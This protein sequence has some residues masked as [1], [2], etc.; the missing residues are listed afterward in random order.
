[1]NS[2]CEFL[3]WDS[4]FFGFR[5]AR[6]IADRLT[7]D[8]I[9]TIDSWAQANQI[10]CLYFSANASDSITIKL[11]EKSDYHLVDARLTF[12]SAPLRDSTKSLRSSHPA[13]LPALQ[14]VA[15]ESHRDTRFYFDENFPRAL[16]DTLYV[17]WITRSCEGYAD[18]VLVADSEDQ[19]AGYV[20]CHIEK[21][22]A[23]G[24]IGLIAADQKFRR[25]GVGRALVIGALD[26]F[27]RQNIATVSVVTTA[28]NVAAQHLYQSCGFT[29]VSFQL[30]YHKWYP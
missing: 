11:A 10:A 30:G 18:A 12:A 19:V 6:V 29:T 3:T 16:C 27:A 17:T 20:T 14:R 5:I 21:N 13:D 8:S 7:L 15:R 1:M 26:W 24:K 28:R 23:S 4:D 22:G 9:A 2:P 25:Q